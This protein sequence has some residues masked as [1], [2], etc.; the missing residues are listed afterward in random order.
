MR[1]AR[2]VGTTLRSVVRWEQGETLPELRFQQRLCELFGK[3]PEELG[4]IQGQVGLTDVTP[5]PMHTDKTQNVLLLR[6]RRVR[7]WTQRYVAE[8]IGTY[9]VN[10]S[11]WERGETIPSQNFQQKLC[12][13]FRCSYED[14]GLS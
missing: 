4:F 7:G 5:L 1:L 9:P 13:L 11:K 8:K 14:L 6:Q 2:E 10:I 3:D 12:E